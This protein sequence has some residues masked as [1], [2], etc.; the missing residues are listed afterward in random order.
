MRIRPRLH[1][2]VA[3]A[4]AVVLSFGA[5]VV[6]PPAASAQPAFD[7]SLPTRGTGVAPDGTI[8]RVE[9]FALT[10]T[11]PNPDE[12]SSR[13]FFALDLAPGDRI[14]DS[15]SVWNSGNVQLTFRL[16]ATDAFNNPDG[17]FDLIPSQDAPT[18]VGSWIT[19][20][21]AHLTVEPCTR[22]QLPITIQVPPNAD[23]GDHAG[24][25][26]AE[27]RSEGTGPDGSKV[28]LLKRNGSRVYLR[29]AGPLDPQLDIEALTT[30]WSGP[31]ANPF[32][33]TVAVSYRVRNVGNVR[34]TSA[35]RVV[36]KD[37]F[38][39]KVQAV[40]APDIRDLLPG[41]ALSFRQE[42]TGVTAGLR[43]TAEVE[44][45][46]RASADDGE[47]P[48]ARRSDATWAIPWIV[49]P[50]AAIVV[51]VARWWRRHRQRQ[52]HRAPAVAR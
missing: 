20:P 31:L 40:D 22:V 12:P 44:L 38:G 10:P 49:L 9:E 51:A 39:R 50:L 27:L 28:D 1:R 11:G 35:Q 14:E 21:Q 6:D 7:C 46:P 52:P 29:V 30:T 26:V 15:I 4:L 5:G 37:V 47:L 23:P 19:L 2:S 13:P 3:T 17:A 18:D 42:L 24:G 48:A 36:L 43:L 45:R 34:L 8:T 41:N 16:Y 33:G 25:I 32:D